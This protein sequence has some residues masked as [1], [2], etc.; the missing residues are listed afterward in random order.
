M[1]ERLDDAL[2]VLRNH[3]EPQLGIPI[4]NMDGSPYVGGSPSGSAGPIPQD[5]SSNEPPPTI[6]LERVS[7]NSSKYSDIKCFVTNT[8]LSFLQKNAKSHQ[9]RTPNPAA[10]WKA[11]RAKAA[12]GREGSKYDLAGQSLAPRLRNVGP[13]ICYSNTSVAVST[14][15]L[16]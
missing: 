14:I 4:S 5:N 8:H 7:S 9:M 3:C 16:D 15:F 6:K 13:E 11:V 10:P 1:E 2:N 12:S